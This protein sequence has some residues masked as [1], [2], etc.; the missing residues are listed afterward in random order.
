MRDGGGSTIVNARGPQAQTFSVALTFSDP[1]ELAGHF[2]G[3]PHVARTVLVVSGLRS[4]TL[5]PRSASRTGMLLAP[6]KARCADAVPM[7]QERA[8]KALSSFSLAASLLVVAGVA[9]AQ[10]PPPDTTEDASPAAKTAPE[11]PQSN[12]P[13]P[14]T[15]SPSTTDTNQVATQSL[16][17]GCRKQAADK[18]LT[19]DDKTKFVKGCKQ[20]GNSQS[21]K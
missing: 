4:Q 9:F 8:M 2:A 18:G 19:G 12:S 5:A 10:A 1:R 20:H 3:G 15:M 16:A 13:S 11:S 7:A 21:G 6:T 17:Q 14:G